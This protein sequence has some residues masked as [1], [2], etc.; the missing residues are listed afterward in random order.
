MM[1]IYVFVVGF[2]FYVLVFILLMLG[3]KFGLDIGII[4]LMMEV[5]SYVLS[6]YVFYWLR[7]FFSFMWG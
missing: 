5:N 2:V 3:I 7:D 1:V 4:G 6:C